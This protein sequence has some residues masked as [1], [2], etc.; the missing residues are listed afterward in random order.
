MSKANNKTRTYSPIT[1][2]C[3]RQWK[4][5]AMAPRVAAPTL[6]CGRGG[7][8]GG[9]ADSWSSVS[10]S[11]CASLYNIAIYWH[12]PKFPMA[13]WLNK[14]LF[15]RGGP[16]RH[17]TIEFPA[18]SV[19]GAKSPEGPCCVNKDCCVVH[20]WQVD[21][22]CSHCLLFIYFFFFLVPFP[23]GFLFQWRVVFQRVTHTNRPLHVLQ[24][25][26]VS[27]RLNKSTPMLTITCA[28]SLAAQRRRQMAL[29]IGIRD[30]G[31]WRMKFKKLMKN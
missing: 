1:I 4:T 17:Q 11:Q 31:K 15:G 18:T 10:A 14:I 20:W 30:A 26:R 6:W 2:G 28:G 9:S 3:G 25:N 29:K 19:V 8:C 12:V 7:I 16:L 13:V 27:S 23:S 22:G 24:L 5:W 21:Q